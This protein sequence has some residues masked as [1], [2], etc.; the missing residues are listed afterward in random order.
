M[1]WS[2]SGNEQKSSLD[3]KQGKSLKVGHNQGKAYRDKTTSEE[4]TI[5]A[6]KESKEIYQHA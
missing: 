4:T 3:D 2:K 6:V 1:V 5:N